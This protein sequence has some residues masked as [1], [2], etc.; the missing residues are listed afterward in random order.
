MI[1]DHLEIRDPLDQKDP[2]GHKEKKDQLVIRDLLDLRDQLVRKVCKEKEAK[3]VF[4]DRQV[5]KVQR[6]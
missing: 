3:E 6:V 4:R 2:E 5:R 1:K